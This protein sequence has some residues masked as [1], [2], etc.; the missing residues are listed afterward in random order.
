MPPLPRPV[1]AT[2]LPP[3]PPA[4][5]SISTS[6]SRPH[7][8]CSKVSSFPS[9]WRSSR[10]VAFAR[11]FT[12]VICSSVLLARNMQVRLSERRA[13]RVR[14]REKKADRGGVHGKP[15]GVCEHAIVKN[16]TSPILERAMKKIPK[17]QPD[18]KVMQLAHCHSS[19][20]PSLPPWRHFFP[21]DPVKVRF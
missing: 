9:I 14:V 2:T 5:A 8:T 7:P 17:A 13:T 3:R 12:F 18:S 6:F 1:S 4:L 21:T 10:P 11:R 16:Q 20:M 19:S 15:K